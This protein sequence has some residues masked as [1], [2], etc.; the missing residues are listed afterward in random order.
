[1]ELFRFLLILFIG[2]EFG[3]GSDNFD[4]VGGIRYQSVIVDKLSAGIN[5]TD[6]HY[7]DGSKYDFIEVN[8]EY[9][10]GSFSAG[11]L[12]TRLGT[13]IPYNEEGDILDGVIQSSP[14][15]HDSL[16]TTLHMKQN[17]PKNFSTPTHWISANIVS[18]ADRA[19]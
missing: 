11:S 8:V 15:V 12:Y 17:V 6:I 16:S 13:V 18:I 4:T 1:M 2:A 14:S 9:A 5:Y 19:R 7:D 3:V 10:F